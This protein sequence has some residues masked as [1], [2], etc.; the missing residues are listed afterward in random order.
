MGQR[1]LRGLKIMNFYWT[2]IWEEVILNEIKDIGQDTIKTKKIQ[3]MLDHKAYIITQWIISRFINI[4][5]K[6]KTNRNNV[7]WVP[8]MLLTSS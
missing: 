4:D 6:L 3:I 7:I 5:E 1:P 8:K 2:I